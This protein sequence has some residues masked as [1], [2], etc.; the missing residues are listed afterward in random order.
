MNPEEVMNQHGGTLPV[1]GTLEPEAMPKKPT[2]KPKPK[3]PPKQESPP[4]MRG[5]RWWQHNT[6]IDV[7]L[8]QL[9]PSERSVWQILFR[10]T[11]RETGFARTGQTDIATRAGIS[12]RQVISA[13]A[14]L[15]KKKYLE[16]VIKGRKHTGPS[17]YLVKFPPKS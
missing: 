5:D 16:I 2:A 1:G 9:S 11:Q 6:F 15:V 12:K 14:S 10:D 17:T 8:R 13:I 4:E 7:H 3:P